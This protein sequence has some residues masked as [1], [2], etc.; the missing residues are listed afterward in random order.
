LEPFAYGLRDHELLRS[1]LAIDTKRLTAIET[2]EDFRDAIREPKIDVLPLV[3]EKPSGREAGWCVYTYEHE[4][5]PELEIICGGVNHKT[6]KAAAVFRQGNLLHF[7]FPPSPEQMTEA[8]RAMFIN[9]ICYIARFTDDRPIVRAR[10]AAGEPMRILDRGAIDRWVKNPNRDKRYLQWFLTKETYE[11]LFAKSRE[12][13]A[14]WYADARPYLF[15]DA[16]G[17]LSVDEEARRYGP[18]PADAV[19]LA[20]AVA[21]LGSAAAPGRDGSLAARKL[22]DRY[23]PEGP[24]RDAPAERW[25]AWLKENRPY[26]FFS[27]PGG[28]RWYLDPLAKRR[29]VPSADLRGPARAT[30]R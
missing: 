8:G 9:A 27:D 15:A 11:L 16:Q 2:P 13:I 28:Y 19:F 3:R 21:D 12:E 24:G 17:R 23:V 29:G 1:P 26:L 30:G 7:G 14:V 5:A 10:S 4:Q 25:N 6:P 18:S 20:K 22:L